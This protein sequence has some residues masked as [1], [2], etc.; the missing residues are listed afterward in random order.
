MPETLNSKGFHA[1]TLFCIALLSGLFFAQKA[2]AMHPLNEDSIKAVATSNAP[3]LC[4]LDSTVF[5]DQNHLKAG[6]LYDVQNQKIVWQKDMNKSYAIASLTKMMVALLTV[7]AIHAGKVHWTDEVA[8]TRDVYY[9]VKRKKVR[10]TSD[11][12]Y[13]L[14]DLFKN[15][16]IASNNEAA[17]Q[18]A[19]YVGEGSLDAFIQRMNVRARELGMMSTYYGNPTGLPSYS[20]LYDNASTPTDLLMLTLEM[21]KYPEIIDVTRMDYADIS[22]GTKSTTKSTT[23]SNHNRLAIDFK[24]QVDGMK[25]GYTKRAGFCLVASSYKCDHRLISIVLGTRAPGTRNDLVRGMFD[26]YYTSIGLDKL[27]PYCTIPEQYTTAGSTD[28]EDADAP[29]GAYVYKTKIAFFNHKV[30]RGEYLSLIADKYKVTIPELKKWNHLK[31]TRLQPGQ[32]LVVKGTVRQKVWMTKDEQ[33]NNTPKKNPV[34][35]TPAIANPLENYTFYT[36]QQGD[37]LF[38]ISRQYNGISVDKLK[39]LNGLADES[40]ITPGMKIKVPKS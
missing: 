32:N 18:M 39:E 25:T 26:D 5:V 13:T 10:S 2:A 4:Q 15:A 35:Q 27:S 34:V 28:N 40:C 14:Q 11:V 7:E 12:S 17:E 19:R 6:L 16:M 38:S 20:R 31:S 24:G 9:W 30:R 8:W 33:G 1:T 36:V 3:F 21:L 22:C 37:T 23:I 29:E